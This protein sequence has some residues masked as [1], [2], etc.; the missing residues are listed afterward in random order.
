M[1]LRLVLDTDV[2]IA[3]LRS[4]NGA[5]AALLKA[6][7][8]GKIRLLASTAMMLEYEAKCVMDEHRTA[9]GLT[10]AEVNIFLNTLAAFLEPI[11]PYF[12]WRPHLIDPDDEMVLETGVNGQA[13]AIVTFNKKHYKNVHKQFGIDVLNPSEAIRRLRQ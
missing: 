3:G 13:D 6:G 5:S 9:A 7:R 11:E 2:V 4:Q 12:L 8:Y 10:K 1:M